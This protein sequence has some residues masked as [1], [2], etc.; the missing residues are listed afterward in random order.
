MLG[1][2]TAKV[3]GPEREDMKGSEG[4]QPDGSTVNTVGKK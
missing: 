4:C 3:W 1:R 2:G